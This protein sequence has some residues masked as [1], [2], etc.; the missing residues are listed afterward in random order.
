MPTLEEMQRVAALRREK[1]HLSLR[2]AMDEVLGIKTTSIGDLMD[3]YDG[4]KL[5]PAE[6]AV[7]LKWIPS[8]DSS[9]P[10]V[11]PM[12]R[13]LRRIA[14]VPEPERPGMPPLVPRST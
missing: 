10:L 1:P 11:G 2:Q 14:G 12:M 9:D 4:E 8:Y 13:K 3:T 7:L 5:T 6:A